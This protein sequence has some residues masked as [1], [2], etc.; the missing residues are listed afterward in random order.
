MI[1]L[2]KVS[3][4]LIASYDVDTLKEAVELAVKAG[5]SLRGTNLE[6]AYLLGAYLRG[7]NLVGEVITSGVIQIGPIGSR[8][9]FLIA[10]GTD[11]GIRLRAGCFYGDVVEFLE[12]VERRHGGNKHQKAYLGAI[13]AVKASLEE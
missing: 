13:E 3:G 9:D 4:E 10:Y 5:V 2:R 1:E 8:G 7:A 12:Q 11:Q 6:G